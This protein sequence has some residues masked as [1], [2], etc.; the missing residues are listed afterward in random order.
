M[1]GR[2]EAAALEV[3]EGLESPWIREFLEA[4]PNR[5]FTDPELI[6]RVLEDLADRGNQAWASAAL[7]TD[8][9]VTM[10]GSG[11]ARSVASVSAKPTAPF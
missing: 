2:F 5:P 8:S 11:K 10:A 9:G 1:L 3:I 4:E 7:A 6:I